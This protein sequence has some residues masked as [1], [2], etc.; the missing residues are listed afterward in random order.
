M[1]NVKSIE[2]KLEAI[3]AKLS[4]KQA[5]LDALKKEKSALESLLE[6][7]ELKKLRDLIKS[8]GKTVDEITQMIQ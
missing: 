2:K 3:N 7:E 5:E 1:A 4:K 8:S 6:E